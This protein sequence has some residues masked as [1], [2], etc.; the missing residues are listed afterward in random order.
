MTNRKREAALVRKEV[1]RMIDER[2]S[3]SWAKRYATQEEAMRR[4]RLAAA[5]SDVSKELR[6]KNETAYR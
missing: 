6:R 1:C 2:E 4:A 3:S 5:L